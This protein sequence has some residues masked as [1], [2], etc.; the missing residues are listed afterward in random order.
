MPANEKA[1]RRPGADITDYFNY[2]LD[3][4]SWTLYA[5]KQQTVRGEYDQDQLAE[6]Q[7]KMMED[8]SMMMMGGM[9]MGGGMD[10]GMTPEMQHMMQQMMAGGMDPSQMD[11]SAMFGG[12]QGASAGQGGFGQG[13]NAQMGYGYDQNQGGGGNRGN[14]GRGRGGRGRW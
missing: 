11:P 9:P 8:M 12:M 5:A 10:A 2:G 1:W 14:F 7:K 6:K 3:E 13:Q 4:F